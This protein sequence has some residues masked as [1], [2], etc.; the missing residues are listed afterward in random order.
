MVIAAVFF[1]IYEY[2]GNILAEKITNVQW[3][4]Y[5]NKKL[6]IGSRVYL[7]NVIFQAIVFS[8]CIY[9]Y[10]GS[11]IDTFMGDIPREFTRLAAS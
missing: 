1:I 8:L 4:D 7:P 5:S 9:F 6:R 10:G 2:A 3:W 11:W